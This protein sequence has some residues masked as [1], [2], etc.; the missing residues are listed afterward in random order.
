MNQIQSRKKIALMGAGNI[1]GTLAYMA[2]SQQL[3]DVVLLDI[4]EGT[5]Q[6]KA[7][8]LSQC[9]PLDN[10]DTKI[11]GSND[12][13][14][15]T[16]ADVVIVTAGSARKPGMSRDDLLSINAK[17]MQSAGQA[18]QQFCP[19]AFV[20]CVTNPLDAM[21]NVLS[22]YSKLAP[23]KIVGM[24]G[25]LDSARFRTFL[26]E[27]FQV[28]VDMVQAYVL[29]GHGDTMVPL[30][31]LSSVAGVSL[32]TWVQQGKLSPE[33]LEA[34]IQ[35]TRQGGGEIVNLLKN[36]SAFYAPAASALQMAE[37][38]LRDRKR[39]L[40]CAVQLQPGQYG[41]EEPLFVGVPAKIGAAGVEEVLELSLSPVEK[42]QLNQSI[43]AVQALNA[44]LK[45]LGMI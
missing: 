2:S 37:S 27:E 15:L 40:P 42:Q 20:I 44:D 12:P 6:G 30:V 45:Q 25:V 9:A 24:A 28:S 35:R 38:Y 36:G 39:I 4:V 3:G 10:F 33:R 34:I 41:V 8:D 16:E 26:A 14:D 7:L 18:I 17:V 43:K 5:A 23:H 11:K 31:E 32:S 1:G 21:V 29:G 22:H 13:A 19:Q